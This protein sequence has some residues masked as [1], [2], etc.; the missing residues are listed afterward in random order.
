MHATTIPQ[1]E[2]GRF[3]PFWRHRSAPV[4]RYAV[5]VLLVGAALLTT[6][7][8]KDSLHAAYF[9]TPFFFCAIVLSSWFGGFG[10]GICST[11][12]S[13]FLL[14]FFFPQPSYGSGFSATFQFTLPIEEGAGA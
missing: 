4:I 13:M 7:A 8:L 11:L 14:G 10:C 5:A 9:Q 2:H 6:V 3:D 1:S 12:L